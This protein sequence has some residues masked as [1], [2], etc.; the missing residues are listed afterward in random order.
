[1][2]QPVERDPV[3]KT[4]STEIRSGTVRSQDGVKI[5]YRVWTVNQNLPRKVILVIHGIGQHSGPYKVVADYISEAGY[6]VVGFDLRG[7]G[8]SE[9]T[10]GTI[11]PPEKIVA[12]VNAMLEWIRSE[13]NPEQLYILGES[14][15]G[16]VLLNYAPLSRAEVSGFIFV[17]PA[18]QI[19]WKQILKLETIKIIPNLLFARDTPVVSLVGTRL[20]EASVDEDFKR[21]RRTDPLAINDVSINYLLGLRR[22]L[23]DWEKNAALIQKP[24]IVLHGKA[25]NILDWRGSYSLHEALTT[26]QKRLVLLDTA[27]HTLFWDPGTPNVFDEIRQW[28]KQ[29]EEKS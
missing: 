10:R 25:D 22:L 24:S 6:L 19:S 17:A 9:G 13:Y 15:G 26:S 11:T 3:I 2:P 1:V 14:M 21:R 29:L 7:H 18:L 4:S 5:F 27:H 12:D 28:L 20:D 23:S 8:M 16:L